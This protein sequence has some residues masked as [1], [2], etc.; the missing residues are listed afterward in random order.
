M[1]TTFTSTDIDNARRPNYGGTLFL[2]YARA[3]DEKPPFD[4][5]TQ[6]WVT[7][8]WT[9]LRWELTNAGLHEAKLWLDRYEIDPAEDFT[10]KIETALREARL[11]LLILSLNWIQRAYCINELERFV[12]EDPSRLDNI[13]LVKKQE[14]REVPEL[15]RNREGYRFFTAE[16]SGRIR[17]FY[18]RGLKD[19]AAYFDTL[20]RVA[21]RIVD[22]LMA[23]PHVTRAINQEKVER[24][25]RTIFLAAPS[26]ELRDAWQRLANDLDGAGFATVPVGG[27][28][29]DKASDAETGIRTALATAEISVHLLG[30]S[31]GATPDGGSETYA[32]LQLR[33]AREHGDAGPGFE[34]I[35]W[36]PKW[37]PGP[38]AD[39]RDPFEV[40]DR[41]GPL[42]DGEHVFAEDVTNLSQWLRR[43]LD[44]PDPQPAMLLLV[45]T[46][47]DADSGLATT[48]ASR[49][50]SDQ[51]SILPPYFAGDPV[52]RLAEGTTTVVLVLW[53]GAT[54][55]EVEALLANLS[56]IASRTVV[57]RLPGGDTAGKA[58]FYKAGVEIEPVSELPPTR[59]A[60]H[61]L[62]AR[63][64]VLKSA[65]GQRA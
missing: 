42:G 12:T 8:F 30:E 10:A 25:K 50:Q 9:Q 35:L 18:W 53:G 38:Q 55:N 33:L 26:D 21:D 2:S 43:R 57:L 31:E 39:K 29:P 11:L 52:P 37:L 47:T 54:Q 20:K 36:A 49:L 27:R 28:L 6:G 23:R 59:G 5:V 63:L 64:E 44:P 4:D 51:T 17:E 62:L 3:D 15:L 19:Q 48:L 60:A 40:V 61:D 58:R 16:P 65:T 13:V 22:R 46:A 34:R 32:R 7:F 1:A 45:A 24:K 14:T 41:F 56:S